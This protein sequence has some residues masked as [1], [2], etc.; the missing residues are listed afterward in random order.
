MIISTILK[1]FA[2]VFVVQHETY[3]PVYTQW[4]YRL[5]PLQEVVIKG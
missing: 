3:L 4:R 5:F 1:A 2:S